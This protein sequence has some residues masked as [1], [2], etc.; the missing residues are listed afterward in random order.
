MKVQAIIPAAGIGE[1]LACDISKPLVSLLKKPMLIHT[2]SVFEEC[3]LIDSVVLVAHENHMSE[4][5]KLVKKSHLKKV[6]KII[7]GG[8][9]RSDSVGNGLKILDADTDIVVVHDA[10]RPLISDAILQKA[11]EACESEDAVIVAVAVKSTIKKVNKEDLVVEE[12]LKRDELWEVQTPQVFKKDVLVRA[13]GEKEDNK[14]TDDAALVEGIGLKV[15]II[16]GDY[17]NIKVTTKEDVLLAEV[18]LS[19]QIEKVAA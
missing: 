2:L 10:A 15:K 11:I 1:R 6:S 9:T 4:I 3:P 13:H 7:A 18:F 14:A 19:E 8:P 17:R 12:T 5:E 16:E